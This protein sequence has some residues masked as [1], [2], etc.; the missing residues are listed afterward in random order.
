MLVCGGEADPVGPFGCVLTT[1]RV[2]LYRGDDLFD[3]Q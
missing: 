3:L 1:K 2:T